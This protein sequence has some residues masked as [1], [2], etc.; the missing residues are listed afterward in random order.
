MSDK[1]IVKGAKTHNLK[2]IDVE[3]P[4]FKLVVITGISGSGK[5]SLA[6]DTIF[7]EGQRRYVESLSTYARQFL[8]MMEKPSV[9]SISGLSPAISI[10]QKT[11]HKNPR[12]TVGTVTEIHD[13]LRLIFAK[14][15]H[16][17]CSECHKK[18]EKQTSSSIIDKITALEEGKKIIIFSPIISGKKGSHE[19]VLEKIKREGFVRMRVDGEI[20]SIAEEIELDPGKKH[21]IDI[22]IDRLVVKNF[23]KEFKTLSTGEKI[24]IPNADRSRLADSV[25]LALKHSKGKMILLDVDKKEEE[26][27]SENFA[28]PLHGNVITELEPR[29][30]SFNSP[31]G[32]CEKCHGLGE[33]LEI[34]E[35]LIIGN[36]NLTLSEG[37]ILPWANLLSKEG[38][39]NQQI[40]KE[41]G[42][43][44]KFDLNTSWK[45]LSEKQRNIIFYGTEEEK[46]S[47]KM[48]GG[49]FSGNFETKFEGVIPNL[50]RR[51]KETD[52]DFIRKQ[53]EKFMIKEV[54]SACGGARLK[55]EMLNVFLDKKNIID[56]SKMSIEQCGEFFKTLE[57]KLTKR[58]AEIAHLILQEINLRLS[59]L[60]QV[61]LG[62]LT[63]DRAANTLSG[64]E[65][66]RIRLATQIGSKLQGVLYVLDEPSIGLHQRDNEK[67]IATLRDLQKIG[68]TVL[69]VEHD[70][71]MIKEAD[72]LIEIGPKAGKEGGEVVAI[73]T[74]QEVMA[75]K[76]SVTGQFLKGERKIKI[77]SKRRIKDD[78]K[79][80]QITGARENNL[81][82]INVDLPLGLFVGITGVSGSGKSTL[83]NSILAPH[84]AEKLNR[85]NKKSAD[86]DQIL[87]VNNL[88]K[89]IVI[90]QSP[91]GRTPR[92]NPATYTGVFT[93][94]REVFAS[95]PE[96]KLRGYLS[97][98]FSFNV[99][100][101]R[102]EHCSGDGVTKIEMHFLPDIYVPC[103]VC[104]GKRFNS[105]TLEITWRGKNI[106]DILQMTV[107]EA[108]SF[109]EKIPKIKQ[110][111]ATLQKVGLDYI[112][113]GQNAVTL[114]GGE[115]QRIKLATELSKKSTGRT[116]YILDEPTTGLHFQDIEKLLKVLNALV[117]SGNTVLII[118]HNLDVIKNCDWLIDLG[119]DG[120][121]GGGQVIAEGTPE[122][123]AENKKSFTGEFLKKIL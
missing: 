32:A 22:V 44:Y 37:V 80:L 5:S 109:F 94:I 58:E 107:K 38:G 35:D 73:G 121:N 68:N 25:E 76:N 13:F 118:E 29:N 56:V 14:I 17:Y 18:V 116:I 2:N 62:F 50:K 75:N 28:C 64:G 112:K 6:F 1:I 91:I 88:D 65:A 117:D 113:L 16:V 57:A 7:A 81:K 23:A 46:F 103:E 53:I 59:F 105:E 54:C 45:M 96:A 4:R 102:C 49:K 36:E 114:S 86:F 71:E 51:Y 84:L 20:I 67:L 108:V 19:K 95:S 10:D 77:P 98:R 110:K 104:K 47:V 120:G 27:F 101:G 74:P 111:L 3:I 26:I 63:L 43:K 72:F 33:K 93:D 115:A 90:D 48:E 21:S 106:A 30:F 123:V 52:S 99:K 82:N 60:Q 78:K 83:I 34:K 11:T 87:G 39:W 97:G 40:I 70:E 42:K 92:S 122:N 119:P 12:S 9:E 66:Q 100:G 15:G 89:V 61:G 85:A 55:K 24:E 8:G 69:V 41:V 31:Y 79:I